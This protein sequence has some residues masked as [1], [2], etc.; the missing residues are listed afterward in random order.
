MGVMMFSCMAGALA[1]NGRPDECVVVG[2]ETFN[3]RQ[4][5]YRQGAQAW[6]CVVS[7]T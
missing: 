2:A 4:F 1:M 6:M 7:E 3:E 5:P